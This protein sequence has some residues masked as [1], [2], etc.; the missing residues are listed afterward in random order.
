MASIGNKMLI[1]LP[2]RIETYLK[3]NPTKITENCEEN[4][5]EN[6]KENCEENCKYNYK[7]NSVHNLGT[8]TE[9]CAMKKNIQTKLFS[10]KHDA[11]KIEAIN[12]LTK[13][14]QVICEE[15][16]KILPPKVMGALTAMCIY[17][18]LKAGKSVP[19]HLRVTLDDNINMG[20]KFKTI[21]VWLKTFVHQL[22][23][24][25]SAT[26]NC[27]NWQHCVEITLNNDT[28]DEKLNDPSFLPNWKKS[29]L[30]D[31]IN[32]VLE[33]TF[34]SILYTRNNP[35]FTI[36]L[37]FSQNSNNFGKM[38][39]VELQKRVAN[40]IDT[41]PYVHVYASWMNL[42]CPHIFDELKKQY[43]YKISNIIEENPTDHL[44]KLLQRYITQTD[45]KYKNILEN[46]LSV[47]INSP[48]FSKYHEIYTP[49]SLATRI[50]CRSGLNCISSSCQQ[51]HPSPPQCRGGWGCI[52]PVCRY[53]HYRMQNDCRKGIDCFDVDCWFR[54]DPQ[55]S[56]QRING[57][58]TIIQ[59]PQL[60]VNE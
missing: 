34:N 32:V 52:K 16:L 20:G 25:S 12:S 10:I 59:A 49:P 7:V 4:C 56:T 57:L 60:K 17:E 54:H 50:E 27:F 33:S 38:G 43:Q 13:E 45:P 24:G 44:E 31:T 19:V 30:Y 23:H 42:Q 36:I 53:N 39:S 6:C 37:I 15:I 11:T 40:I 29:P 26:V 58:W 35:G 28:L 8:L 2:Q 41:F 21:L 5:K 3:C 18:A 22:P 1:Q 47:I 14:R 9:L 51:T 55:R 48:Q 46:E